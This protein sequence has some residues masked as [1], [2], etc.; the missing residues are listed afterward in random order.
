[1]LWDSDKNSPYGVELEMVLSWKP[2]A[3]VRGTERIL[4]S[5]TSVHS[6]LETMP[7]ML[8]VCE[9]AMFGTSKYFHI[10]ATKF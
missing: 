6:A 2:N 4:P 10:K 9:V 7:Q 3:K 5:C 1:M 8:R